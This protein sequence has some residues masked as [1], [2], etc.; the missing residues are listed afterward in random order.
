MWNPHPSI[1]GKL[2]HL[3]D[4]KIREYLSD[5]FCSHGYCNF[6][7]HEIHKLNKSKSVMIGGIEFFG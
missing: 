3:S 2:R 4:Q 7:I 5:R 6:I 1:Y